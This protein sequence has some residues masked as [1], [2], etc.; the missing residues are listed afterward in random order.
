[1]EEDWGDADLRKPEGYKNT[2]GKIV[3]D[4]VAEELGILCGVKGRADVHQAGTQS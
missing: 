4:K 1:M 3:K 2:A